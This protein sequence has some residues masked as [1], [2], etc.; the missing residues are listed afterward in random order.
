MK[1]KAQPKQYRK[2]KGL[3]VL[4][5]KMNMVGIKLGYE[6]LQHETIFLTV[7]DYL[8]TDCGAALEV[9]KVRMLST[10]FKDAVDNSGGLW[11][12]RS[13]HYRNLMFQELKHLTF[14]RNFYAKAEFLSTYAH[15]RY[16]RSLVV[17]DP[18]NICTRNPLT[19]QLMT[20][21]C[22]G[23]F[24]LYNVSASATTMYDIQILLTEKPSP[25]QFKILSAWHNRH[26]YSRTAEQA[27]DPRNAEAPASSE[28]QR[29]QDYIT[30]NLYQPRKDEHCSRENKEK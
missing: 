14:T 25:E 4:T 7:L 21:P 23:Y 1:K 10:R 2:N 30:K 17:E 24:H 28:K 3:I 12:F 8:S 15:S 26:R 18:E 22:F 6:P 9:F 27:S 5:Q 16:G 11:S 29:Q 13:A 20:K 19:R